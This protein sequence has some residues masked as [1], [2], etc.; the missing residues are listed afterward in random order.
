MEI[1]SWIRNVGNAV[2]DLI[3]PPGLYCNSCGK[4]TDDSRTY[5]L[6]NDCM[7]AAG[8]ITDRRCDKCGRPLSDNNSGSLCFA[9]KET[10]HSSR[11]YSFD[12]GHACAAYGSVEQ[13]VIFSFKYGA[14]SDIGDVL[15]EI[16]Y[17]RMIS[18][19]EPD[20]L[21]GIYDLVIPVPIYL[22][23]KKKRG[24]NQAAIMAESFA[25][26]AGIACEAEALRRVR[27][28]EPMK[29]LNP[30]ERMANIGGAFEIRERYHPQIS[31]ARIL[32]IDD[33]YTTGATIDEIAGILK[34]PW[35]DKAGGLHT[36][37][38]SVDFLTYAA[39]ADMIKSR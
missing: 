8:W 15:G 30:E 34:K 13:S 33:I 2:L 21:A 18:E 19:Y 29:G 24:F 28:T 16:L 20:V 36:G 6:C 1:T 25:K 5:G 12:K 31:D 3:Y 10:E 38:R 39:G 11:P 27:N 14:R 4:I 26:R 7:A 9:C 22:E 17:D 32:L 23:K 37:A 35:Y